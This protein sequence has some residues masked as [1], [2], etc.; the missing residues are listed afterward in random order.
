M[1]IDYI[2][3]FET[4]VLSVDDKIGLFAGDIAPDETVVVNAPIGSRYYRTNNEVWLKTGAG[5]TAVNWTLDSGGTGGGTN[6]LIYQATYIRNGTTKDKWLGLENN[7]SPSN[8]VPFFN[9]WKSE[10]CGL[11]FSNDRCN[12]D[13]D[14]EIYSVA[15]GDGSSPKTLDFTWDLDDV[16]VARKTNFSPSVAFDAGDKIAVFFRDTGKDPHDAVLTLFF[17]ITDD[18]TSESTEDHCTDLGFGTGPS[19]SSSSGSS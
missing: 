1:A 3:G 18:L 15:E 7:N 14:I 4:E 5:D 2:D 6:G 12:V 9:P 10:L 16:R 8:E 19:G 13:V 17:C 11:M